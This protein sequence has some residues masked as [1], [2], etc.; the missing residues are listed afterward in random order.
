MAR[1][2]ALEGAELV[3]AAVR[4]ALDKKAENIVLL[5]L[6]SRSGVADWFVV[7]DSDNPVHG[8]AIADGI[9]GQLSARGTHPWHIE[10][11]EQGRWVLLDYTDV[12]VH[13]MLPDLRRYY[14]LESL[15][16]DCPRFAIAGEADLSRIAP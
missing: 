11:Q 2:A 1:G 16:K 13:V 12:V 7:C 4:S 9:A 6:R 14:Q 10:G 5:D 8:R 3:D 15:W